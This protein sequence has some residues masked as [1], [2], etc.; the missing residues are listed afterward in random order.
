MGA[1]DVQP[2]GGASLLSADLDR[3]PDNL[4]TVAGSEF[5]DDRIRLEE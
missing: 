1:Q 5:V 3:H 2:S 4:D